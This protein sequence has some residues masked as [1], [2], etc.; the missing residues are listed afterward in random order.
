MS[1]IGTMK[2]NLRASKGLNPKIKKIKPPDINVRKIASI[3]VK[4]NIAF[5]G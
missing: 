1:A 3:G 5:E 2:K 4:K